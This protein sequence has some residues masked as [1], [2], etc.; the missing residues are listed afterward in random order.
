[1]PIEISLKYNSPGIVTNKITAFANGMTSK[2]VIEFPQVYA[3]NVLP[4]LAPTITAD[5]D[6]A[7]NVRLRMSGQIGITYILEKTTATIGNGPIQW[8]ALKEFQLAGPEHVHLHIIDAAT[9]SAM[10]RVRE[11]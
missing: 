5:R 10:F 4:S 1:M 3:V 9:T 2:S 6:V 8:S 11:K 7:G